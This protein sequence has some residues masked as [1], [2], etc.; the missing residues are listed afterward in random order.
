MMNAERTLT[1]KSLNNSIRNELLLKNEIK[2]SKLSPLSTWA[3]SCDNIN[4]KACLKL[5][6]RPNLHF[7]LFFV[8]NTKYSD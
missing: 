6:Y 2:I 1:N 4:Y 3:L 8:Q 5:V 7:V